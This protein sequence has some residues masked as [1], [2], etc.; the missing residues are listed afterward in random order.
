M[1]HNTVDLSII[2][3]R[4]I[5][6]ADLNKISTRSSRPNTK[7]FYGSSPSIII[8]P[9]LIYA[10]TANSSKSLQSPCTACTTCTDLALQTTPPFKL[11]WTWVEK[12][13]GVTG[14]KLIDL[15]MTILTIHSY[16]ASIITKQRSMADHIQ[17]LL[18]FLALDSR[19]D[20][21]SASLQYI[22]GLTCSDEGRE[23]IKSNTELLRCLF[24]LLMDKYAQVSSDA[25]L[26]LLNLSSAEDM[27]EHILSLDVFPNILEL[28]IDPKWIHADKVCMILSNLTRSEKGAE[29]FLKAISES[30]SEASSAKIPTLH[31]L[32]DIFGC[33]GFNNTANF[34][35]LATL[36]LNIS[37]ISSGRQLFLNR[38]LCIVP[39]LLPFT[40]YMESV[41]RRGGVV[42]LLR[43][44]C[45]EVG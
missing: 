30:P 42:G 9:S 43:N 21:K 5:R 28:V 31:Q 40:Q 14:I 18:S 32:V 25:H 4:S 34:H 35:Y 15:I 29:V 13:Q 38:Q 22:I 2:D 26:C 6:A 3:T 12:L 45:F 41:I 1:H 16:V 36:F 23:L 11:A 17:D 8:G 33:N 37:Q 10:T 19:V 7:T 44:L 39:H 27:S 20:L 24:D